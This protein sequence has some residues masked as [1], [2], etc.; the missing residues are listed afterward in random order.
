MNIYS[1][2]QKMRVELQRMNLKKSGKNTFA[3]YSYYELGDFLPAINQLMLD[4]GV[5]SAVTFGDEVASLTLV[6]TEKPEES[7]VFTS[8][9]KD[10][11]LKGAHPIQNLGAVETYSRRYLYMAA[12]EIVE[13]DVLDLTQGNDQ[14]KGNRKGQQNNNQQ[15]NNQ[16]NQQSQLSDG[17]RQKINSEFSRIMQLS[18]MGSKKLTAE[19]ERM[20]GI[21]ISDADDKSVYKI[22]KALKD[23]EAFAQSEGYAQ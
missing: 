10:A 22:F 9:M 21:K 4:N 8:P 7:I 14:Q 18:K 5:C 13:A 3:G 12:F 19:V 1:K 17:N 15:N 6:N 20:A 16:Q 11:T 2:L 23:I